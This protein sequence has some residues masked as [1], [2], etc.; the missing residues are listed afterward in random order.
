MEQLETRKEFD[1]EALK[2]MIE[3][4]ILEIIIN[5]Q[6]VS[7]GNFLCSAY[8]AQIL[9]DLATSQPDSWYVVDYVE[10]SN[11]PVK[12]QMAA[13]LCFIYMSVFPERM[14]RNTMSPNFYKEYGASLY[15]HYYHL[16]NRIIGFHMCVKY[17]EMAEITRQ[18]LKRFKLTLKTA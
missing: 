10:K 6:K 2:R 17:V 9:S 3:A 15:H 12:C 18:A 14:N 16:T 5:R 13:D 11:I 1:K 4:K 7:V 8:I